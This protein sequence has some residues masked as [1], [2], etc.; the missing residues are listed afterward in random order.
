ML[1]AKQ[2]DPQNT[3][4][5]LQYANLLWKENRKDEAR[6]TYEQLLSADSNNRFALEAMGYLYREDNNP[7][8]AEQYFN[9]LA[10]AYPD[11]YVPYLALG[12]LYVQIKQFDQANTVY[13]T[14]YKLAPQNP[15]VISNAANAA[16]EN[17]Q[18]KLAGLWVNRATG[19]VG[20]DPRVMRERERWLF[21]E[22]KYQESADLGYKVLQELP[23]DRNASVYLAYDLYNLGR[24]DEVLRIAN[25]Y[26]GVLPDE[27]NFPLLAGHVHKQSQ[28]LFESVNDYSDAIQRDP[29]MMEAYVNRGYVR[30]DMQDA[31]QAEATSRPR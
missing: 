14:A 20:D 27:P 4:I 26:Q 18:M 6:K 22:G 25:K 29:R 11:D 13:E 8:M 23:K 16:I 12:D 19:K 5:T 21:H 7:Q 3:N 31:Q 17:Q 9:K 2:L 30:N 1:E 10:A 28:L 24:Y 15:V